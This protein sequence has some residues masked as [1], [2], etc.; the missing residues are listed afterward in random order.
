MS[1]VLACGL[2]CL[3]ATTADALVVSTKGKKN[4]GNWPWN[5]QSLAQKKD[6]SFAYVTMYI[7]PKKPVPKPEKKEKGPWWALN[8]MTPEETQEQMDL[9]E[10]DK[11]AG[12]PVP[13]HYHK[14]LAERNSSSLSKTIELAKT[15]LDA[16]AGD[17]DSLDHCPGCQDV[18]K[19]AQR[20][21][22]VGSTYPL[23]VVTNMKELLKMDP[24]VAAGEYNIVIHQLE[25]KDFLNRKCTISPQNKLHF[26]KLMIFNMTKYDKMIWMDADIM[27]KKNVDYL[28]EDTEHKITG[29]F[30]D[31]TCNGQAER[32]SGGFCSGVMRFDPSQETMKGIMEYQKTMK[33]CWGDQ[34]II[35][36]YFQSIGEPLS[37]FPA[38]TVAFSQCD[39]NSDL[40]HKAKSWSTHAAK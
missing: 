29:Q 30:D 24:E 28:F 9:W 2:F 31:F 21:K 26:Q 22:F 37:T 33:T 23:V 27:V 5:V 8:V 40:V 39:K 36:E 12:K 11:L 4:V 15:D 19:M 6:R 32:T 17:G 7:H 16:E 20:L 34:A 14:M 18:L 38:T 13:H 10:K 3:A 25:K 1:F 35:S